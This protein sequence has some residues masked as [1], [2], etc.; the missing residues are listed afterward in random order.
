MR[1]FILAA[2]MLAVFLP[3]PARAEIQ[4][5]ASIVPVHSLAAGVMEGALLV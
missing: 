1:P 2:A 5:V 4:V 3:A